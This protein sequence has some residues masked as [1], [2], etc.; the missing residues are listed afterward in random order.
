MRKTKHPFTH[1]EFM[2]IYSQVPRVCVDVIVKKDDGFILTKRAIN[3]GGG[4][5]RLI[6]GT[7]FLNE[8]LG[9]AARRIAKE[10]LDIEIEILKQLGVMEFINEGGVRHSVSI[11]FLVSY[12]SGTIS[13]NDEADD[14]KIFHEVPENTIIEHKKFLNKHLKEILNG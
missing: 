8:T 11:A 3:P 1:E 7:V 5:W 10:E 6:G 13:I 14:Y 12:K 9:E 4:F 2:A